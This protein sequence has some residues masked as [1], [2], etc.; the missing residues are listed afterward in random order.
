M[1]EQDITKKKV[2]IDP[3]TGKE[4]I[5]ESTTETQKAPDSGEPTGAEIDPKK[6]APPKKPGTTAPKAPPKVTPKAAPK[7]APAKPAPKK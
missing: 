3:K 5:V 4:K 6:P 1:I 7:A 2:E